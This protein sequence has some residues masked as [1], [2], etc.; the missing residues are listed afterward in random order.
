[1]LRMKKASHLPG[2]ENVVQLLDHFVHVGPN[3][4]HLFLV[5]QL[6]WHNLSTFLDPYLNPSSSDLRLLLAKRISPQILHGLRF[7]QK[8]KLIHNGNKSGSVRINDRFTSKEC[9]NQIWHE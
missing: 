7:L 4:T 9:F 6:M 3:G 2:A 8:C 1:M 5:L